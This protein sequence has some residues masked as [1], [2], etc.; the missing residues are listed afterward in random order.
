MNEFSDLTDEQVF[1]LTTEQVDFYVNLECAKEGV[2][3]LPDE[4]PIEPRLEK[5]PFDAVAFQVGDFYVSTAD[6]ATKILDAL[7]SV[8][9]IRLDYE[10]ATGYDSKV[11]KR[12]DS[13]TPE[14]KQIA[15]Y[16]QET[17]AEIKKQLTE[18]ILAK[19]TYD[20]SV[21]EYNDIVTKRD[22]VAEWIWNRA[23][24]VREKH[25]SQEKLLNEYKRYLVLSNNDSEI[26]L[27]FLQNAYKLEDNQLE[28]L[29]KAIGK[30]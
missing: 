9:I 1:K 13:F 20:R 7:K 26:A 23:E 16:S 12:L 29:T 8:R 10:S 15:C 17:F 2:L 21:R 4:R 18:Y 6:E 5:P 28:E 22:K 27:N 3:L 11:V 30:Q 19:N 24:E 14:I 25:T